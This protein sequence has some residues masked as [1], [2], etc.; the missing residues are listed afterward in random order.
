MGPTGKPVAEALFRKPGRPE[1]EKTHTI[2][3]NAGVVCDGQYTFTRTLLTSMGTYTCRGSRTDDPTKSVFV[4]TAI[5][6]DTHESRARV[7]LLRHEAQ[8]YGALTGMQVVPRRLCKE[9]ADGMFVMVTEDDGYASLSETAR[10]FSYF[11]HEA[12][13]IGVAT[14]A[15]E[16]L[17]RLH[18]AR[19]VHRNID[20][21]HIVLRQDDGYKWNA[22]FVGLT[23]AIHGREMKDW[24]PKHTKFPYADDPFLPPRD[25]VY[26]ARGVHADPHAVSFANDVESL[27]YSL[28][29][30]FGIEFQW[31]RLVPNR[32]RLEHETR[33]KLNAR[34]KTIE[35]SIADAKKRRFDMALDHAPFSP[36]VAESLRALMRGAEAGTINYNIMTRASPLPPRR[37]RSSYPS[38]RRTRRASEVI[39][40]SRRRDSEAR[41]AATAEESV[42]SE[43]ST[44]HDEDTPPGISGGGE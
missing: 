22:R 17:Q 31:Q 35:R 19:C 37:S 7:H 4:K 2:T 16:A 43:V 30:A 41:G 33:K 28:C 3:Q 15:L 34:M 13:L 5:S 36:F 40:Q 32:L 23:H 11:K 14:A 10:R 9:E 26:M 1:A 44:F 8:V 25:R 6:T 20:P 21:D 24:R 27:V 18:R 38:P 29:T 42:V 39:A 12:H